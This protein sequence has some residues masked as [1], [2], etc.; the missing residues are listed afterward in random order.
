MAKDE[1]CVAVSFEDME[2]VQAKCD[3]LKLTKKEFVSRAIR[4]YHD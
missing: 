4:A 2:V 1:T 3:E